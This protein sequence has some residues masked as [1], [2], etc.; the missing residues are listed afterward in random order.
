MN[1]NI[2]DMGQLL[3]QGRVW[4]CC[5]PRE[6]IDIGADSGTVTATGRELSDSAVLQAESQ[7]KDKSRIQTTVL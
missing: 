1:L 5:V 3:P 6:D 7:M 4:L 2:P